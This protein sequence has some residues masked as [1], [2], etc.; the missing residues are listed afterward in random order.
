MQEQLFTQILGGGA[1]ALT[2]ALLLVIVLLVTGKL[3]PGYQ[4][5]A[6]EA[7]LARY[8]ELAFKSITLAERASKDGAG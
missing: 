5:K 2:A 4:Y 6:L 3:V 7:K 1:G 8:E